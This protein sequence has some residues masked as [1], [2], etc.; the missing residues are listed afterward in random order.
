MARDEKQ[1]T[2]RRV[3][4]AAVASGLLLN[5][6][7]EPVGLG[8]LGLVALVPLFS[9]FGGSWRQRVLAGWLAG[10]LVQSLGY[11]WIFYTIRDFGGM[12]TAL[13]VL[14]GLAFWLYQGLDLAFWL[15]M[16]PPI[17]R[18]LPSWT[19]PFAAAATWLLVQESLFPYTFPWHYGNLFSS[20]PLIRESAHFV[21]ITGLGIVAVSAQF[22][23]VHRR[24]R[25]DLWRTWLPVLGLVVLG[26]AYPLFPKPETETW[27]IGVVQPN[28]LDLAKG[29][30]LF[31]GDFFSAH[32]TP[33]LGFEGR[34]LDL[35]V[36]PE[37]ALPFDL[38]MNDQYYRRLVALSRTLGC[39][40]VTGLVETPGPGRYA[41]AIWM[42][43][44]DGGPPQKY[45]KEKLVVFSEALPWY[46]GWMR[47]FMAG[48][49]GFEPGEDNRPFRYRD[50]DLVPLICYEGLFA[51]YVR[52]RRGQLML[53]L[54]ND[55][56]FGPT[57][58]SRLHLQQVQ[59][60]GVE[61]GVPL[62]RATNSGL[63]CWVDTHGRVRDMG[64]LYVAE[65]HLFEVPVPEAVPPPISR[66]VV[67]L[68]R[69]LCTLLLLYAMGRAMRARM[70]G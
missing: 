50:R 41:N 48:M 11:Y 61:N 28:L 3:L 25:G 9:V 69:G 62:V 5:L 47:T 16:T 40:I 34:D 38:G 68:L 63:S 23:L 42:I 56:W 30:K 39:P 14:G 64:G 15:W 65:T 49:G 53:N 35:L 10:F 27:R 29:D 55:A 37:T 7:S 44:P 52:G 13:S 70:E 19:R 20:L 58:A 8:V 1:I 45:R 26:L 17:C 22:A 57:K 51:D 46:L 33:S 43:E 59:M 4:L 6:A 2:W 54:T 66:W 21:G 18:R 31:A 60:R 12:S 32:F 67:R 36:W 24:G